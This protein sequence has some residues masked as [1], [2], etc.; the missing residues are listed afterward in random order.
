MRSNV[1]VRALGV[2]V[3]LAMASAGGCAKSPYSIAPVSGAV[4]LDGQPL[5]GGV[6]SFQPMAVK[7]VVAGPGSTGRLDPEGRFRLST[8]DGTPGAVVGEHIVRIYS[9]SPESAPVSDSDAPAA[10]KERVPERFNYASE[11]RFMVP[12]AG[13]A[14]ADFELTTHGSP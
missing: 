4:S 2:V 9:R 8:I 14:D 3:S 11:L 5:A 10:P 7:G 13:S 1:V 12:M 6:V